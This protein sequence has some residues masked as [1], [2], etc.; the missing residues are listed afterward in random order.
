MLE[1][2]Y[3]EHM[4]INVIDELQSQTTINM[5]YSKSK[6]DGGFDT[7]EYDYNYYGG[8][9]YQY[10]IGNINAPRWCVAG[11]DTDDFDN[12]YGDPQYTDYI[13][14][15][16]LASTITDDLYFYEYISLNDTVNVK[17]YDWT[18]RGYL[19]N[20]VGYDV[21]EYDTGLDKDQLTIY[22][23]NDWFDVFGFDEPDE[24]KEMISSI[25]IFEQL[26]NTID[27]SI[28][29][30]AHTVYG[31]GDVNQTL[32]DLGIIS[33][34]PFANNT[35]DTT[36]PFG[37]EYDTEN[38][39]PPNDKLIAS[40]IQDTIHIT[41]IIELYDK[42]SAAI[43]D[44]V[45]NGSRWDINWGQ[46]WMW[47]RAF[48]NDVGWGV[49]DEWDN[50]RTQWYGCDGCLTN[51]PVDGTQNMFDL[52]G[53][54][55]YE[56]GIIECDNRTVSGEPVIYIYD[57]RENHQFEHIQSTPSYFWTIP[58]FLYRYPIVRVFTEDGEEIL[59]LSIRHTT[60]NSVVICFSSPMVGTV[61]LL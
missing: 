10:S 24:S 61:R 21:T 36:P 37:I 11:F 22:F 6:C 32:F 19:N 16:T 27:T 2:T 35:F 60:N 30:I 29:D 7:E 25:Q 34:I 38:N 14:P 40:A 3:E 51:T 23:D 43:C 31:I 52:V 28:Y 18:D 44:P 53:F 48:P 41:E 57:N 17:I 15:T 33:T 47:E 49:Y 42:L 5:D 54:D 1:L 56:P 45:F 8:P 9:E 55:E 4:S 26:Y 50:D 58:H 20:L 59:P 39:I 12:G 13:S 46:D